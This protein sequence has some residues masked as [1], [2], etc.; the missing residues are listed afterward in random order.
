MKINSKPRA[1]RPS[2]QAGIKL[3]IKPHTVFARIDGNLGEPL[4]LYCTIKKISVKK[5]VEDHVRTLTDK[6]KKT[7][8]H[9]FNITG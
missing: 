5:L 3:K 7:H 2:E 1:P 4:Q 9:L 6:F 8:P